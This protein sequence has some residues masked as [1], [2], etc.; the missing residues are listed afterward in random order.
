MKALTAFLKP[1][2]VPERSVKKINKR[3]FLKKRTWDR[4]GRVN[5]TD[6]TEFF[7]QL[8]VASFGNLFIKDII[9]NPNLN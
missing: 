2:V 4:D 7:Q 9:L 5:F 3:F 1:W 8:K 6:A